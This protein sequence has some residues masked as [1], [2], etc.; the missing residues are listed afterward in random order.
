MLIQPE[1]LTLLVWK[2]TTG[3]IL[4]YFSSSS[5][6]KI[7]SQDPSSILPLLFSVP[8]DHSPREFPFLVSTIPVIHHLDFTALQIL[9][10]MYISWSSLLRNIH[11]ISLG[12]KYFLKN[13]ALI[14]T[15][16]QMMTVIMLSESCVT[17]PTVSWQFKPSLTAFW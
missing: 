5:V 7:Y 14:S 9:G 15:L 1:S 8:T 17:S 11:F 3:T 13:I 16:W 2:P 4:T 12:L 10:Y 6:F